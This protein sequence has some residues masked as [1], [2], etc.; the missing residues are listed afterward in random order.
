MIYATFFRH[1]LHCA[2]QRALAGASNTPPVV[3]GGLPASAPQDRGRPHKRPCR[4]RRCLTSY[5]N[6]TEIGQS[7]DGAIESGKMGIVNV[8]GRLDVVYNDC[9]AAVPA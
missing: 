4:R 1:A 5:A 8:V 6:G 9:K 7:D 3:G 2:Y